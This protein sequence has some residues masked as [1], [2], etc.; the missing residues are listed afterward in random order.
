VTIPDNDPST[1][2]Y[3]R[4]DS[5]YNLYRA[6][7]YHPFRCPV[8]DYQAFEEVL[9]QAVGA[10][11]I[12]NGLHDG[13]V[14]PD[15]GD[16]NGDDEM[17]GKGTQMDEDDASG[18]VSKSSSGSVSNATTAV[19][20]V[21]TTPLATIS[22]TAITAEPTA[23]PSRTPPSPSKTTSLSRLIRLTVRP[24]DKVIQKSHEAIWES[25]GMN[26]KKARTF[27]WDEGRMVGTRKREVGG[28]QGR[29]QVK[30]KVKEGS[31][32]E[33]E[34]G[35][36]KNTGIDSGMSAGVGPGRTVYTGAV[37][38][39]IRP[40]SGPV[41][42]P[43]VLIRTEMAPNSASMRTPGPPT[44]RPVEVRPRV[45]VGLPGRVPPDFV[46][47]WLVPRVFFLQP[48]VELEIEAEA[49]DPPFV[50]LFIIIITIIT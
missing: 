3:T 1:A 6:Y 13:Q 17:Q 49:Y 33:E 44:L 35:R 39:I 20:A 30:L 25:V 18:S 40:G 38:G 28:T 48:L 15:M 2:H 32:L 11:G 14:E 50:L 22:A 47:I 23:I 41:S 46:T 26:W 10:E 27:G 8:L 24:P 31:G 21:A 19:S 42:G 4:I 37:T 36:R 34:H 5:I 43:G 16:I 9:I 12:V 7:A 45:P 29:A